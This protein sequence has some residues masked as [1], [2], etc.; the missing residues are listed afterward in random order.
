MREIVETEGETMEQDVAHIP[1]GKGSNLRR[2]MKKEEVRSG[3]R[4]VRA[5]HSASR[6]GR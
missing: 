1:P 6:I 3:Q 4:E 5:E 2:R